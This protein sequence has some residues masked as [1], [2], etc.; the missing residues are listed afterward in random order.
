M[1]DYFFQLLP[2]NHAIRSMNLAAA[3]ASLGNEPTFTCAIGTTANEARLQCA[4]IAWVMGSSYSLA[5][6]KAL[7][8]AARTYLTT[9]FGLP[10]NRVPP[11]P[12]QNEST[13]I[14]L[15]TIRSPPSACMAEEVTY[16][17]VA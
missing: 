1:S 8:Q 9:L 6:V 4:A 15:R 12:K 10:A 2:A 5:A 14:V 13:H 11:Q 17:V 7:P 16:M 3:R